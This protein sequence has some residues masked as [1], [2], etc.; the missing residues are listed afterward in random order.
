MRT[1]SMWAVAAVR[2][3]E[4]LGLLIAEPLLYLLV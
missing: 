1:R 2:C 3:G 4:G